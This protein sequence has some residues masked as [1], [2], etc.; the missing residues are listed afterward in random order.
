MGEKIWKLF[1]EISIGKLASIFGRLEGQEIINGPKLLFLDQFNIIGQ[2]LFIFGSFLK[3]VGFKR[4]GEKC[5]VRFYWPFH[6]LPGQNF[7][8]RLI[9]GVNFGPGIRI[10]TPLFFRG[11]VLVWTQIFPWVF[12]SVRK[13]FFPHLGLPGPFGI[14]PRNFGPKNSFIFFAL[15]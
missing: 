9:P 7:F 14:L 3:L 12:G 15:F 5:P 1:V 11:L 8:G 13:S 6:S 2:N 4:L 10:F